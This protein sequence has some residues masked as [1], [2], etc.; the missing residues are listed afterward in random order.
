MALTHPEYHEGTCSGTVPAEGG[1][2]EVRCELEALPRLGTVRGRV[3]G[4]GGAPVGGATVA[5]SGPASRSLVAG[6]DGAFAAQELPPGTY[7]ARVEAEDYLIKQETFEVVA[8]EEA[9]PEIQ[10]ISRPRNSLV[11]VRRRDIMIR[12]QVNFAT[13]SS[14]ILPSSSQLLS[15]V[16]DVIMRHPEI[17]RIEI[18]GH[19]DNRGGRAHNQ[20]LSQRRAE[21]VRDW[22]VRAGVEAGRLEA[23]GYGQEQ[24]LVPNITASNR[25]RNRRVQFVIQEQSDSE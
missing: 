5:L 10:L 20:D 1:D 9:T 2:V 23:R 25:A 13:D 8:R 18:Q 4:E 15:E 21:A 7:T 24:P 11:R 17:T 16:A 6:P 14:E 12:R 19:T 22:L 3:T